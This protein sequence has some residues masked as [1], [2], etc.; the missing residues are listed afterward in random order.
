MR[1]KYILDRAPSGG[2]KIQ[3]RCGLDQGRR[4]VIDSNDEK[5]WLGCTALSNGSGVHTT[6]CGCAGRQRNGD[7]RTSKTVSALHLAED[8]LET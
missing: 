5:R 3:V 1:G 4:L 8:M 7:Q 6:M 2:D